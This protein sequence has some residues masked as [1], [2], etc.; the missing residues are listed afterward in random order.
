MSR[1]TLSA[2][3]IARRIMQLPPE[4]QQTYVRLLRKLEGDDQRERLAAQE[5]LL[6]ELDR[7]QPQRADP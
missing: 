5:E 2:E 1:R 4:E 7:Q 3:E 6:Q